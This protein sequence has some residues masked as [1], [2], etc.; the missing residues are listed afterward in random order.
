MNLFHVPFN[1]SATLFSSILIN[2]SASF[3][4]VASLPFRWIHFTRTA[5]QHSLGQLLFST[6][7]ASMS[8]WLKSSIRA[9]SLHFSGPIN[10]GSWYSWIMLSVIPTF[11]SSVLLFMEQSDGFFQWTCVRVFQLKSMLL[12][13][14]VFYALEETVVLKSTVRITVVVT[15]DNFPNL[16]FISLFWLF[17]WHKRKF[18]MW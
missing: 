8:F 15:N 13:A 12:L 7:I 9:K 16:M 3:P 1:L 2:A 11:G 5:I 4:T 10:L 17:T 18:L 14:E 6:W